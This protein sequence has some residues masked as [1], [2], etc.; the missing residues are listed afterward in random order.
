MDK[1]SY[2]KFKTPSRMLEE[3]ENENINW[4]VANILPCKGYQSC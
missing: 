2:I 3:L 4:Y 1:T